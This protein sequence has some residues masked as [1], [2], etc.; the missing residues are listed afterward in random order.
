MKK[1]GYYIFIGMIGF[2]Y[3]VDGIVNGG[4]TVATAWGM[5][6]VMIQFVLIGL[7]DFA[8]R[9]TPIPEGLTSEPTWQMCMR[10]KR[11]ELFSMVVVMLPLGYLLNVWNHRT[12]PSCRTIVLITVISL[13]L[14]LF[15]AVGIMGMARKEY[16]GKR[17]G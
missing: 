13:L 2:L 14:C 3:V 6:I 8:V 1:F 15:L 12:V 11:S 10:A 7:I 17:V 9:N 16:R 4:F 5:V